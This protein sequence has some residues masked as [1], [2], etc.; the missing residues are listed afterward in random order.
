VRFWLVTGGV[1]VVRARLAVW[2]EPRRHPLIEKRSFSSLQNQRD[3]FTGSVL[4]ESPLILVILRVV[5]V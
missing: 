1:G 4:A 3:L 5:C 2:S